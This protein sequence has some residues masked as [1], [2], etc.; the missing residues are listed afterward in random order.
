MRGLWTEETKNL[1]LSVSDGNPGALRVIDE[2]LHFTKWFE[3]MKWCEKN[4]RGSNLWAKYKDDF[5]CQSDILGHWIQKKMR[6]EDEKTG[7][8][9]YLSIPVNFGMVDRIK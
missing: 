1:A 7:V 5:K 2:L 8:K 4:L 3:M 6:E 9:Q